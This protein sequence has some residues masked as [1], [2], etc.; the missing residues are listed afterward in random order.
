[1]TKKAI[2]TV[3]IIFVLGFFLGAVSAAM[4]FENSVQKTGE[5]FG[6]FFRADW[7]Q[8]AFQA[9]S[10]ENSQTAMWALENLADILEKNLVV[11]KRDKD[12]IQKDLLLTYAR[13]AIVSQTSKDL[14]KYQ[15]NLSK[16][17]ALSK[18]LYPGELETKEELFRFVTKVDS[19]ASKKKD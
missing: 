3:S 9:Y 17:L 2:L 7:E 15:E 10:E 4:Y 16:A 11:A 12:V 8:R 19:N 18:Q 1:M 14:K 6:L 13:L 5:L